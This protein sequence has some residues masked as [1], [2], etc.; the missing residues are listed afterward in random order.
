MLHSCVLDDRNVFWLRVSMSY[1]LHCQAYGFLLRTIVL[2]LP[3]SQNF[4]LA[5]SV[6]HLFLGI[7][8]G[9]SLLGH[10]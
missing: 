10:A 4:G 5:K 6:V 9:A 3:S 1:K 7:I 8:V 2:A